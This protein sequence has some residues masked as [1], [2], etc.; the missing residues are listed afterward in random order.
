MSGRVVSDRKRKS[1]LC[2]NVLKLIS[3][4]IIGVGKNFGGMVIAQLLKAL[5]F[6]LTGVSVNPLVTD[7]IPEGENKGKIFSKI[8]GKGYSG[9]CYLCAAS[10]ILSGYLYTIKPYIPIFLCGLTIL[11]SII[12]SY[13]FIEIEENQKIVTMNENLQNIKEGFKEIFKSQ[14]LKAL[15]LMIGTI[16]GLFKEWSGLSIQ[17]L[18]HTTNYAPVILMNCIKCFLIIFQSAHQVMW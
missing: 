1:I 12:I 10:T 6:A 14:R 18:L 2:G 17:L 9:Y 11:I 3:I 4:T 15:L 16:W 5:G 13:N 7:S 8:Y